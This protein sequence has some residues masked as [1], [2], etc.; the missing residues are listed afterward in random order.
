MPGMLAFLK[1]TR[2]TTK[3]VQVNEAASVELPRDA[4]AMW[5]L[6]WDPASS[7][8][9]IG[10]EMGV[11]LPGSP[12]GLGEIQA[13][14]RR[15][16]DGRE[17]LL[18]EVVE[19]EPGRRAVTRSLAAGYPAYSTLTIESLG[20]TPA[21]SRRSFASTFLRAFLL[22]KCGRAAMAGRTSCAG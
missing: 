18:H 22:S 7:A 4:S 21:G 1:I 6:M 13:F 11:T 12:R 10:G 20:L 14:I 16:A 5:S 2:T 19:F 3:P 8:E 9:I 17:G 15:T